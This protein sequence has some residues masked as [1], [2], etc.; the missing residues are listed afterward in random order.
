MIK[1]STLSLFVLLLCWSCSEE[2]SPV[3]NNYYQGDTTIVFDTTIVL[4][5]ITFDTTI[6]ID[7]T[8]IVVDDTSTN[9]WGFDPLICGTDLTLIEFE[10]SYEGPIYQTWNV[11]KIENGQ[12]TKCDDGDYSNHCG[13]YFLNNFC[14]DPEEMNTYGEMRFWG[15]G[16]I[17]LNNNGTSPQCTDTSNVRWKTRDGV[18]LFEIVDTS[19][20]TGEFEYYFNNVEYNYSTGINTKSL[21]FENDLSR[22][23][24]NRY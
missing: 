6:I 10:D 5:T 18:I 22:L 1:Y 14:P 20:T 21:I 12:Y 16:A 8:I 7:T 2:G 19:Q 9:E 4:D 23:V 24:L 15:T 11:F 3:T 13:N 17:E